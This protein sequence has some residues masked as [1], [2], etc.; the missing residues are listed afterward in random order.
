VKAVDLLKTQAGNV[1]RDW[2]AVTDDLT[3]DQAHYHPTG[4]V[5][6]V[7]SLLLHAASFEDLVV[8]RTAQGKQRVWDTEGWEKKL[9]IPIVGQQDLQK[10]R[11][12]KVDFN[13]VKQYVK[14]VSDASEAYLNHVSDADLDREIETRAGKQP[15]VNML[16]SALITHKLEHLGEIS[17][18]K[19]LQGAKGWAG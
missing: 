17:V 8:N 3:S 2:A 4:V 1:R 7:V 10:A 12:M 19:G 13:L 15:L 6:P 5:N 16:S 14:A 11:A 9:G 18:I